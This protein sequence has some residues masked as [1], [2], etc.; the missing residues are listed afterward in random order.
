MKRFA[1]T[2]G[3]LL[4]C[5]FVAC[6]QGAAQETFKPFKLKSLSGKEKTLADFSNRAI[7]IG[8]FFPTCPYC[9]KSI[10]GVQRIYDKYKDQGLSVVWINTQPAQDRRIPEWQKAHH[11]TVPILVTG[12][13]SLLH[14]DYGIRGTP[15]H[16]LI[17][18]SGEILLHVTGYRA[19]GDE[20]LELAVK[21]A[22][23][24][25]PDNKIDHSSSEQVEEA[26]SPLP[27]PPH[28]TKPK[29]PE[30]RMTVE[31]RVAPGP[32]TTRIEGT[33][34]RF[35]CL[36]KSA[37]LL[38]LS[39]G[40]RLAFALVNPDVISIKGNNSSTINFSCGLQ[41]AVS[42]VLEYEPIE[43]KSLGTMGNIRSIEIK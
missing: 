20:D 39:E 1:M 32:T 26:Y 28:L 43:N 18:A 33:L 42:L 27:E 10:P 35:D 23:G 11:F 12:N 29:V 30:S 8:F 38:I 36:G 37:R 19:G 22:L 40:K 16:Y 2:A 6:P 9:N 25:L 4:I 41:K 14:Y 17:N 31:E 3:V 13:P 34:Q 24:L 15:T 5:L 7:L 21:E